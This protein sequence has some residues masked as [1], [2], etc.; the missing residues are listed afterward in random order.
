MISQPDRLMLTFKCSPVPLQVYTKALGP[1][2]DVVQ[3]NWY[4]SGFLKFILC[5]V[6]VYSHIKARQ[7]HTSLLHKIGTVLLLLQI[8]PVV[9]DKR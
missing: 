3:Y 5:Y 9:N 7:L 4:Y 1:V 8:S 2:V 6:M